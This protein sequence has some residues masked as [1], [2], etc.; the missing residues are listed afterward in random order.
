MPV[1]DDGQSHGAPT[2]NPLARVTLVGT[3]TGAARAAAEWQARSP[4]DAR[5]LA[6][7]AKVPTA[8]WLGN[9]SGDVAATVRQRMAEAGA[10]G[11]VPVFV[12]Y[13]VP[14]LDCGGYSAGGAPSPEA[15][16][17]WIRAVAAAIGTADAIVIVEP[18]TLALLCGDPAQRV[19]M[20]QDAV[21][22]LEANRRTARTSTPGTPTGPPP[23]D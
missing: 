18:D 14:D 16:A 8:T 4:E 3:N 23:G 6:D 7:L 1:A 9:W 5:L 17:G 15:Y 22:A 19:R 13:N 20:L 21:D 10:A 12:V 2:G 11:G